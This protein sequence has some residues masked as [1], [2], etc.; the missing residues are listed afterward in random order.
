MALPL[1]IVAQDSSYTNS[2]M[3]GQVDVFVAMP[4]PEQGYATTF[5]NRMPMSDRTEFVTWL[6]EFTPE[7]QRLIVRSLYGYSMAGPTI[8]RFD[9]TTTPAM[10]QPVLI[11]VLEP[12]DQGAF[13]TMWTGMTP[14]QQATFVTVAEDVYPAGMTSTTTTTYTS[15][16]AAQRFAGFATAFATYLPEPSRTA[17]D[18]MV[19]NTPPVELSGITYVLS[20]LTPDQAGMIVRALSSIDREAK[21]GTRTMTK[22]I[23]DNDVRRLLMMHLDASERDAFM[24][25]WDSMNPDLRASIEIDTRDAYN[26]GLDD[27][28][29]SMYRTSG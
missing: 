9:S 23:T 6:R 21:S 24:S 4:Q 5:Y 13:E 11:Q 2:T 27:A 15:G 1:S 18:M 16:M 19:A 12:A 25:M 14:S 26:G 22:G 20:Q 10:A 8:T 7:Q 28:G 29:Y 17:F 3:N